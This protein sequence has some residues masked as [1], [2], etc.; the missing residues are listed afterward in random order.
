MSKL[1]AGIGQTWH[2][3]ARQGKPMFDA[4]LKLQHTHL[5]YWVWFV[6]F[7]CIIIGCFDLP[8]FWWV[9]CVVASVWV[10]CAPTNVWINGAMAIR[11][12]IFDC[13]LMN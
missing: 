3:L 8:F 6:H 13:K 7:I 12:C 2:V 10:V 11:T 9:V 4:S 1:E 5:D